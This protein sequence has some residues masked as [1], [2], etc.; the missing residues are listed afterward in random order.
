MLKCYTIAEL[1]V[2]QVWDSQ[3]LSNAFAAGATSPSRPLLP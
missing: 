3:E 2:T 1:S